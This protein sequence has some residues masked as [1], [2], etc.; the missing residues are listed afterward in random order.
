MWPSIRPSRHA[1]SI[2]RIDR[3]ICRSR[4]ARACGQ[5]RTGAKER[6][7]GHLTIRRYVR[8]IPCRLARVTVTSVRLLSVSVDEDLVRAIVYARLLFHMSFFQSHFSSIF[9]RARTS[10]VLYTRTVILV[11]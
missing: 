9:C 11:I 8:F 4:L 5:A 2:F 6:G 3:A 1:V 10:I 7:T